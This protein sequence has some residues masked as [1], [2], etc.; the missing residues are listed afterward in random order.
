MKDSIEITREEYLELRG[1]VEEIIQENEKLQSE[2]D[3]YKIALNY[4]V[5][6]G[7]KPAA[8]IAKNLLSELEGK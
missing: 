4:F 2:L 3:A 8:D 5:K 7:G 6:E 1:V